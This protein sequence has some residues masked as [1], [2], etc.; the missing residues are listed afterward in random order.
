VPLEGE[1]LRRFPRLPARC[2]AWIR[3][4]FGTAE[5]ETEDIGPRGCRVVT[6]R[7]QT[8]GSL[9]RLTL[10]SDRLGQPLVVTGQIVWVEQGRPARAGVSF[11]GSATATPGPA[12]W[13]Q[14]LAA[15]ADGHSE[16]A[17]PGVPVILPPMPEL[18]ILVAPPEPEDASPA[19]LAARLADRAAEL[20][21]SGERGPAEVILRRALAFA[22]EDERIA[23]L[24]AEIEGGRG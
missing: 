5:G 21:R 4:R 1:D 22:P 13:F 24:L 19:A 15:A 12:A 7:A 20:L 3:D 10:T 14:S 17:A 2:R 8:V 18:D 16:R 23:G 6:A 11:T 9:V